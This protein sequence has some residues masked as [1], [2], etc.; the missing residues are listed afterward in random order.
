MD[1]GME[2]SVLDNAIA[3]LLRA[4]IQNPVSISF[5]FDTSFFN[6]LCNSLFCCQFPSGNKQFFLIVVFAIAIRHIVFTSPQIRYVKIAPGIQIQLPS[7][8]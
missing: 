4:K 7:L 3:S 1:K 8:I 6:C 5:P 2:S